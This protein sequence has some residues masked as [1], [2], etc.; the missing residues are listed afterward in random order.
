MDGYYKEKK[1]VG[2]YRPKQKNEIRLTSY[3]SNTRGDSKSSQ[4]DK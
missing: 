1:K 4:K 2:Q 3:L